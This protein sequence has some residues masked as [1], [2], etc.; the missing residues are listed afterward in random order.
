MAFK[1]FLYS[2]AV[3]LIFSNY[4]FSSESD[5]PPVRS[6][7]VRYLSG[8]LTTSERNNIDSRTVLDHIRR[9]MYFSDGRNTDKDL[10]GYFTDL[11][12]KRWI[13]LVVEDKQI[14]SSGGHRI[15][16]VISGYTIE[17]G[18]ENDV[19]QYLQR[20]YDS[21]VSYNAAMDEYSDDESGE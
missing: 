17:P 5:S 14:P 18:H 16:R 12:R 9:N 6:I 20:M 13:T 7:G 8:G 4:V 21:I 19:K 15:V 11:N 2:L 3:F 1:R 10:E